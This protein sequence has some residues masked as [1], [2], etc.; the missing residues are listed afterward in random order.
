[1]N[2]STKDAHAEVAAPM[3]AKRKLWW[4]LGGVVF[5]FALVQSITV[6]PSIHGRVIDEQTQQPLPDVMVA[7]SWNLE[8]LALV[9]SSVSAGPVKVAEMSTDRNGAFTFPA[10][11][12]VHKP[13]LPFSWFARSD[14]EMPLL[15]L[16]KQGYQVTIVGNDIFGMEGPAHGGGFLALRSSSLENV[17]VRMTRWS[18]ADTQANDRRSL[19]LERLSFAEHMCSRRWLCQE[20]PL[21]RSL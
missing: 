8:Q 13:V 19:A 12:L 7:A 20:Q 21:Q 17:S 9:D 5:F 15:T 14:E 16:A 18:Q 3:P 6:T 10:A 11:L 2:I 1:M 4:G